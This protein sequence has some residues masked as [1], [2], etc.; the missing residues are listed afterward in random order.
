LDALVMTE[1]F[2]WESVMLWFFD[3]A[4]ESLSVETRYDSGTSEFIF[5]V[6]FPDGRERIERFTN[7]ESF[8]VCLRAFERQ[9]AQ[10]N[11]VNRGAPTILPSGWKDGP[12]R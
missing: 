6:A 3:R 4:G 10:E 1:Q 2:R 7:A 5:I 11:W 8:S 12:A 9:L